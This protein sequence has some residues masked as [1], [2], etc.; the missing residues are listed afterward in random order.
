MEDTKQPIGISLL[1]KRKS[2]NNIFES[3]TILDPETIFYLKI[4]Y[5][6]FSLN[7]TNLSVIGK[8]K[9]YLLI[10]LL[11]GGLLLKTCDQI[12]FF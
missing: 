8:L 7:Q 10:M 11:F 12:D 9:I 4:F 2:L 3:E 5:D 6:D 1:R